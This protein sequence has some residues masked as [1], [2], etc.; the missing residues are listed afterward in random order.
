[1]PLK[2]PVASFMLPLALLVSA[3]ASAQD[4]S[5]FAPL[6][7]GDSF[8]GWT[9]ENTEP[10][11]FTL[12]DGILTVRGRGGWLRSP[13]AYGDFILRF[14]LRF[15]EANADSGVFLRAGIGTDFIL[16]WP[17]D[18]YQVQMREIT[19]NPSDRPLPLVGLY[20]HR[21]ADG[22]TRYERDRVFDLYTGVGEW[23]R[24]EI[25]ARGERITV[26]LNGELVTTADNIVN[27]TGHL[28]FQSEAGTIE[29]RNLRIL[30]R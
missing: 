3:P 18:A 7:P 1:M 14:E 23:Q 6:F 28:G 2:F 30:E 19:V 12:A 15:P 9:L 11:N 29:Y 21:I 13:R 16:G 20:R 22:A 5:D 10:E 8:E 26:T 25:Q 27:A 4:E 17:G 24:I